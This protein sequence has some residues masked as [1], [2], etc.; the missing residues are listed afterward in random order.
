[1]DNNNNME[2]LIQDAN[3]NLQFIFDSFDRI[4]LSWEDSLGIYIDML[5]EKI[6]SMSQKRQ[7][8]I[9][10]GINSHI[11]LYERD[12]HLTLYKD[13]VKTLKKFEDRCR[14]D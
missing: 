4:Y 2:I 10:T 8:I 14:R 1:M 9:N 7:I 5:E 6:W 13:I 3:L 11:D 12:N